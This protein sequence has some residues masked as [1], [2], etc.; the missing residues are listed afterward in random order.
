MEHKALEGVFGVPASQGALRCGFH[1]TRCGP[2]PPSRPP[3]APSSLPTAP[4]APQPHLCCPFTG[5]P[6]TR[7]PFLQ[8]ALHEASVNCS[9]SVWPA[10]AASCHQ[11]GAAAQPCTW[12][13]GVPAVRSHLAAGH[14]DLLL[15]FPASLRSR[16]HVAA[17]SAAPSRGGGPSQPGALRPHRVAVPGSHRSSSSGWEWPVKW[18]G[19]GREGPGDAKAGTSGQNGRG[20]S[21]W[22]PSQR[23]QVRGP[24]RGLWGVS[25]GR[26]PGALTPAYTAVLSR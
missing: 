25:V 18:T 15:R 24:A 8:A 23:R 1:R 2:A 5:V 11:P 7:G 22:R 17:S 4:T 12:R 3:A 20:G 26:A 6:C 19:C 13:S 9:V 16:T 14:G 10:D 21:S